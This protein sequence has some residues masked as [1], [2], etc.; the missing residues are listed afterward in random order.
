MRHRVAVVAVA[1]AMSGTFLAGVPSASTPRPSPRPAG[2]A[3]P[4]RR[5]TPRIGDLRRARPCPT[6]SAAVEILLEPQPAV[7]PMREP[8]GEHGHMAAEAGGQP[9]S[10]APVSQETVTLRYA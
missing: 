4:Q 1:V 7:L 9:A 3:P 10:E 2:R 6:P 8:T 5:I